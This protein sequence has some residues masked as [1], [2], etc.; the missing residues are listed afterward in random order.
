MV[1]L[2]DGY[3]ADVFYFSDMI[4]DHGCGKEMDIGQEI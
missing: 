3:G 4:C 2:I 1:I